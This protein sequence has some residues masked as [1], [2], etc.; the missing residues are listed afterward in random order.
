VAEGCRRIR[1]GGGPSTVCLAGGVFANDLLTTAAA[2]MLRADG[3]AVHR[4]RQL[5][6]GDG[7]L[8][9][10]QALVAHARTD[11]GSGG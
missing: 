9:L 5:P 6:P 4:A 7:G 11:A 3:F 2:R 10:G 8:S 1:A